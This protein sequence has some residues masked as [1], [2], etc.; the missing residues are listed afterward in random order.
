MGEMKVSIAKESDDRTLLQVAG[1]ATTFRFLE[2]SAAPAAPAA[3]AAPT[4]TPGA[5]GAK[6]GQG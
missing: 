6:G 3:N 2:E 4:Q 1:R 5:A